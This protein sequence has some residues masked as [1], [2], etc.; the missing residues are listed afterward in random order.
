MFMPNGCGSQ[1]SKTDPLDL[2]FQVIVRHCVVLRNELTSS[3]KG[4]KGLS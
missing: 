4:A 1:E 3:E 2:E